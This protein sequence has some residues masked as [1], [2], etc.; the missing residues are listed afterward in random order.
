MHST[1]PNLILMGVTWNCKK[2]W[3]LQLPPPQINKWYPREAS[4]E[5]IIDD[6]LKEIKCEGKTETF[7]S[8]I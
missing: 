3:D 1:K 8:Q 6:M 2:T 4:S 7:N 5:H